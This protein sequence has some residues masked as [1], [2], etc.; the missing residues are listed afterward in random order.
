MKQ[1]IDYYFTSLSPFTYL[2]HTRFLELAKQTQAEISYKPF[3]IS[4]VFANSGAVA[5]KDRPKPRQ[6]YRLVELE[7]WGRK[8]NLPLTLHPAYFPVDP[9]LADRCII[10]LQRVGQD[11]GVFLGRVL[12][13][14]WAEEQDI[15]DSNVIQKIL[16]SLGLDSNEIMKQAESAEVQSVYE[17]NTQDAIAQGVLG[18]PSYLLDGEQFWGQDRLE[19]L[20][21]K[22]KGL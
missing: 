2:G 4:Q 14:C 20:E 10:A 5:L 6:A 15:A 19:L 1:S 3:I 16:D 7:R 12:A 13:A 21:D 9:S 17:Q 18:A 11:A 8:R 22:L